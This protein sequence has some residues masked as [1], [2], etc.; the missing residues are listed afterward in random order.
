MPGI[1]QAAI[2][3]REDL[4]AHR[5][6]QRARVAFLEV[7][8]AAAADEERV[9][10]KGHRAVVEHVAHAA[11]G[12]AWSRA[13]LEAPSAE[14]D[15]LSWLEV[16]VGAVRTAR[17][18]YCDAAAEPLL[19]HPGAGDVVGV[20]MRLQ[21]PRQLEAQLLDERDVAPRLLEHRID[22]HRLARRGIGEKVSVC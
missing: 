14:A 3:Q 7:G 8:A 18:R 11:A 12:V 10:G 4:L 19:E 17:A 22:Q 13:R 1:D 16:S 5:V 20:Q 6:E 21:R 9:A 15:F 2:R